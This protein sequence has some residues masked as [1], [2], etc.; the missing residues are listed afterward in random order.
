[1]IQ[2]STSAIP[3]QEFS[4]LL[5]DQKCLIRLRQVG[6]RLFCDL[7][8]NDEVVFEGRICANDMDINCFNSRKFSGHLFFID[9]KGDEDPQYEGLNDRWLLCYETGEERRVRLP[10]GV[11][12]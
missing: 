1:M 8:C 7:E 6:G 3:W 9:T 10:E 4:V 12:L 11:K 2:I 5:D